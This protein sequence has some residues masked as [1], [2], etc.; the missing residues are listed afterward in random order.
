[1]GDFRGHLA[2]MHYWG[3]LGTGVTFFPRGC[4]NSAYFYWGVMLNSEQTAEL[5]SMMVGGD[6][7]N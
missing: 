3:L 2:L 7:V 4:S 6:E 1:M 5:R